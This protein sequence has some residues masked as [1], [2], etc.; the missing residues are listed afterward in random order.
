[1][2][3]SKYKII[4]RSGAGSLIAEFLLSEAGV[5][6]EITFN[7]L[8]NLIKGSR[9][10]FLARGGKKAPL[11]EEQKTINFAFPSVVSLENIYPGTKLSKKLRNYT[12]PSEIFEAQ[13]SDALRWYFMSSSIVRGGDSRISDQAID[14]VVR[15]VIN[16]IW[17]SYSFFTLYANI[18]SYEASRK[19]EQSNVL[20]RYILAKTRELIEKVTQSMEQYD[21]PGATGE[22]R[23]F[24]DA[25]N[26]WS[27]VSSNEHF[28][29]GP[30]LPLLIP[31]RSMDIR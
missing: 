5:E 13:G 1:M 29:R 11:K 8:K 10:I 23:R 24:I 30:M 26:N 4:G 6:Y 3:K 12:E 2:D 25:L 17:N 16:P 7:D 14:D 19:T 22:I 27:V 15:Q 18:D 31:K 20:D 21:L 9:E 28:A